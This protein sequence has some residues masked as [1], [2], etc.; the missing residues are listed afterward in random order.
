MNDIQ[1][2]FTQAGIS[3]P[4]QINLDG[5]LHRFPHD[6]HDKK[7]SAWYVG[8]ENKTKK[9]EV[10]TVLVGGSLKTGEEIK[11]QSNGVKIGK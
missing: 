11:Y 7:K 6:Q 8:F 1:N 9:G 2:A 4:P 5:R 10:F 3:N